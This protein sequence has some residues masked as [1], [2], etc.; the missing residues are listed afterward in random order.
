MDSG[1]GAH[2]SFED[3]THI[4]KTNRTLTSIKPRCTAKELVWKHL[5][6]FSRRTDLEGHTSEV[7]ACINCWEYAW[8]KDCKS[9]SQSKTVD[10]QQS[11]SL[12]DS[13]L[14]CEPTKPKEIWGRASEAKCRYKHCIE[15][16]FNSNNSRC[17]WQGIKTLTGYKD[18]YTITTTA[19]STLPDT[20]NNF[21]P[22][23]KETLT[24][25]PSQ[26]HT[27]QNKWEKSWSRW[28]HGKNP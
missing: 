14:T 11:K 13:S 21:F 8:N 22:F 6:E 24:A 28:S 2:Q 7:L 20:L 23:F 17:M 15:E 4:I 1:T 27:M 12:P 9:I 10:R 5:Q 19:D 26:I 18:S 16:C 25:I 3:S